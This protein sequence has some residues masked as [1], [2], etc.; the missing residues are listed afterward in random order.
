MQTNTEK[1]LSYFEEGLMISVDKKI[2]EN[3][4]FA[5]IEAMH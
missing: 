5:E 2:F 1:A 4:K 3:I